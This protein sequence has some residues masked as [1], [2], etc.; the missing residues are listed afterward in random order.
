MIPVN[1]KPRRS[2]ELPRE[3]WTAL[4]LILAGPVL[5]LDALLEEPSL[6]GAWVVVLLGFGCCGLLGWR[7]GK[8]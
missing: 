4:A 3:L 8:G 7:G 6:E 2:G 1:D 5:F